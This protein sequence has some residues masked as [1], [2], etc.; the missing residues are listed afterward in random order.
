[1]SNTRFI[2]PFTV[3]QQKALAIIPKVTSSL[4]IVG[5][6][7]IIIHVLRRSKLRRRVY[8]RI[9]LV[10]SFMDLLFSIKSFLS[11]WIIP[12]M[13]PF[14]YGAAGNF[15]TCDAWAFIGHGS[16]LSSALYNGTLAIYFALTIAYNYREHDISGK[17]IEYAFHLFPLLSGWGTAIVAVSLPNMFGPIGWTCWLGTYPP[18]CGTRFPCIRGDPDRL[19]MYRVVLFYLFLWISFLICLISMIVI[20]R[21][22]RKQERRMTER[23]SFR[24]TTTLNQSIQD[25]GTTPVPGPETVAGSGDGAEPPL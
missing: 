21:V 18:G 12:S 11:T 16:S 19:F 2:P 24:P 4:S 23:Y 22:I 3:P 17:W 9:L 10:M 7:Y 15:Q 14:V 25:F 13:T 1:M 8:T 6:S 5:S 20:F